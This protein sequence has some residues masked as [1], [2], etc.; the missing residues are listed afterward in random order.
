[1]TT[2]HMQACCLAISLDN[3]RRCL[4]SILECAD[5]DSSGSTLRAMGVITLVLI[6]VSVIGVAVFAQA[7]G[8]AGVIANVHY[9]FGH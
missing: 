4:F 2:M 9:D 8:T 3:T 7:E 6:V 1:M 5:A